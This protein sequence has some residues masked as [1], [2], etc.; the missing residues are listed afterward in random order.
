MSYTS[1]ADIVRQARRSIR[2]C[3]ELLEGDSV[4]IETRQVSVRVPGDTA[5]RL[6]RAA[7]ADNGTFGLGIEFSI[8]TVVRE[9][10][11]YIVD[12]RAGDADAERTGLKR[13]L[14]CS[15]RDIVKG[16]AESGSAFEP[17]LRSMN[18]PYARGRPMDKDLWDSI[19]FYRAAVF[20][21]TDEPVPDS[22]RA[23]V[24]NYMLGQRNA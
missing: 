10:R 2:T 8:G 22:M 19:R 14:G 15:F 16:I 12:E 17:L 13:G 5:S 9:S 18:A 11:E 1:G 20:V 3:G 7:T 24:H 6:Q 23:W 21:K 4:Q